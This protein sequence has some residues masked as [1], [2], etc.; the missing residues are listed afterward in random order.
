MASSS[1][2]STKP[3]AART[4]PEQRRGAGPPKTGGTPWLWLVLIGVVAAAGVIAVLA[5]RKDSSDTASVPPGVEQTRPA[6]ITGTPLPQLPDS[7]T[8]PAIGMVI[9]EVHGQSFD[10]TPVNIL[11]DG[12]P[13]LLMFVAH[14]CPH[15]Q[16]EVPLVVSHLRDN[17]LPEGVQLVAIATSTN[18]SLPN[19][20]P[21]AWLADE[22][23]P[24]E[25]MADTPKYDVAS[26]YGLTAFPYFVAV[27]G[28]GKVVARTTGEITMDQ[29]DQIVQL[30][31]AS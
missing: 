1:K 14:W 6:T 3:S 17:P 12:K 10:G 20:P 22:S 7:G 29:F 23:W 5:T 24:G 30:A 18:S 8:D 13:K 25:T 11:D 16:R 4:R 26:A 19:Y 9:P 28:S 27:D 21:S 2:P 31:T 15:C